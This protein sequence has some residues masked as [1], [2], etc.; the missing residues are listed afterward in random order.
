MTAKLLTPK[1]YIT[2][3]EKREVFQGDRSYLEPAAE[4]ESQLEKTLA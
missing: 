1:T 3:P 2:R 4:T